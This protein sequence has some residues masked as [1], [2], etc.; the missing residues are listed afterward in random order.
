VIRDFLLE[1]GAEE[2][3]WGAQEMGRRQLEENARSLL[4]KYRLPHGALEIFS[5]PRRLALIVRD[6][7][8]RQQDREEMIRGPA[9]QVAFDAEGKPTDA[10]VG[11]ARS[12]GVEVD[13]LQVG[14]T[15]KGEFVFAR[16]REEGRKATEVLPQLL[17]ELLHSFSFPKSMRWGS[18]EFRFARPVRWILAIFGKEVVNFQLE[19]LCASNITCGHRFLAPHP[20]KIEEP[21]TYLESLQKAR[22]IAL[23][24]RRKEMVER[25]LSDAA[26][27]SGF[28]PVST[29]MLVEEVVDLVEYPQVLLGSFDRKY[30]HLPREILVTAMEEHQRYF[31]V[32]DENGVLQ[33]SFLVVHNGD[34]RCEENIRRGNERVLKAR[35]EDA[36]F[37]FHEDRKVRLEER[38]EEL[39][40]V[41]YQAQLGTLYDKTV[42]LRA[43]C[44]YLA[45]LLHVTEEEKARTLRA[46]YLAKADLVT[47]MVTEFPILQGVVGRIYA[48][49]DGEAEEVARAIQE[50]YLPRFLGDELP[51]TLEGSLLSLAEKLDNLAG[52][53]GAGLQ[54]SGS[55]DPYALRRQAQALFSQLLDRG[56]HL[57]LE[58][59]IAFALEQYAFE[60]E[61]ELK[62]QLLGFLRQRFRYF[63]LNQDY[64]YDLVSAILPIALG[65]PLDAFER[66]ESLVA[67]RRD[68]RLSRL[69]TAFERCYNLSNKLDL[70]SLDEE[71]LVEEVERDLHSLVTWAQQ[72]LRE[73]LDTGDYSRAIEILLELAPTIDRLFNEIFIMGEDKRL[74]ENRLALL[75][76]AA[77]LF[78]E[79]ADLSRIVPEG[80][81]GS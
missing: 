44:G 24:E 27:A 55:E 18:G 25:G 69:Y 40:R 16:I 31:P 79:L 36:E 46:A 1:I 71:L 51:S 12:R 81:S 45:E 30:L 78:L 63:L 52:G 58:G 34:P 11:F 4:E 76:E 32:E 60:N 37:F 23:R 28:R 77:S 10:A 7:Q 49:L 47:S 57:N 68:G 33:P 6:L 42:R 43:V 39:K 26:R 38:V 72:P 67:A 14:K 54:P 74:R 66:L 9:V 15:E 48:R 50:Q 75:Q 53:F 35:L 64:P 65:D 73:A 5:T 13:H 61:E 41:V 22:V 29:P 20:V 3:P 56:L 2:L 19:N 17:D 80:K 8:E 70:L 21:S 62:A 59:A